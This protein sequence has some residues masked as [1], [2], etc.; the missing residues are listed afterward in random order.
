[1]LLDYYKND[2]VFYSKT[3]T[4][5]ES[6]WFSNCTLLILIINNCSAAVSLQYYN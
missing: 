2:T 3:Q 5:Y 4:I 6:Q 1:M